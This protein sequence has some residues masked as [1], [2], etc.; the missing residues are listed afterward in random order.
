MLLVG[1]VA[2][3]CV[4]IIALPLL[5]IHT[6]DR[7]Q[8]VGPGSAIH[9]PAL[10]CVSGTGAAAVEPRL[11]TLGLQVLETAEGRAMATALFAPKQPLPPDEE[12]AP[13]TMEPPP[14]PKPPARPPS[15]RS[16]RRRRAKRTGKQEEA[17]DSGE[18]S[19]GSQA[20][21]PSP[22]PPPA[23]TAAAATGREGA[24]RRRPP[25]T[26]E[27]PPPPLLPPLPFV[28]FM[29]AAAAAV[30]SDGGGSDGGGSDGP[31]AS[32]GATGSGAIAQGGLRVNVNVP[33]P[34]AP[35]YGRTSPVDAGQL[36]AMQSPG[37]C[38]RSP[39]VLTDDMLVLFDFEERG[40]EWAGAGEGQ[41]QGQGH[42][43]GV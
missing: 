38:L 37:V 16:S 28:G 31:G 35:G 2:A 8:H 12:G 29:G 27:S 6:H 17:W 33:P 10:A 32:R 5:T 34:A 21:A 15:R 14:L 40:G 36:W 3:V 19:P 42:P 26:G 41:G 13:V 43:G 4:I 9:L 1:H 39:P 11:I 24:R 23:E 25:P 22:P 18:T 7:P 20:S 30:P